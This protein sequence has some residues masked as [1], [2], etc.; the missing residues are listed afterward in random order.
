MPGRILCSSGFVDIAGAG[1]R[2][3]VAGV[4]GIPDRPA[5]FTLDA[6]VL[7][8]AAPADLVVVRGVSGALVVLSAVV[9]LGGVFFLGVGFFA[10]SNSLGRE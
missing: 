10:I 5:G 6:A 2:S 7:P 1:A 8:P 4:S 3:G 9:F